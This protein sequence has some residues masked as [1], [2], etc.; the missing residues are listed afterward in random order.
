MA[1]VFFL[2]IAVTIGLAVLTSCAELHAIEVNGTSQ[3][4]LCG[5]CD[6]PNGWGDCAV[7]NHTDVFCSA[8]HKC[9]GTCRNWAGFYFAC[10]G[11]C[12]WNPTKPNCDGAGPLG[13]GTRRR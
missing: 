11:T 4:R 5:P 12:R 3:T 10:D 7:P 9:R 8:R 2:R 6:T 1:G 13:C